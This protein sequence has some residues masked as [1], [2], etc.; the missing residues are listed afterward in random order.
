MSFW[1][2]GVKRTSNRCHDEIVAQGGAARPISADVT[3]IAQVT[4]LRQ[5]IQAELGTPGILINA[6]GIFGPL[7]W[8]E[9]SDPDSGFKRCEPI[10]SPPISLV[11]LL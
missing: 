6:V 1:S 8:I 11:A 3:D 10:Q 5:V 4:S 7:T 9:K 2:P